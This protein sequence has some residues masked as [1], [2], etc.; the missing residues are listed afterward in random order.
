LQRDR[1]I[2][3]YYVS[4]R[5]GTENVLIYKSFSEYLYNLKDNLLPNWHL[6]WHFSNI[7]GH[8][9]IKPREL[10]ALLKK[11]ENEFLDHNRDLLNL[12][13]VKYV[14]SVKPVAG[15][16]LLRHKT[17]SVINYFL[18]QNPNVL[19]RAYIRD[20]LKTTQIQSGSRCKI[21]KY[22]PNVVQ[23]DTSLSKSGFLFLSDTYYPG[24]KVYVNGEEKRIIKADIFFRAVTLPAGRHEVKFIYDPLTFK[25]GSIISLAT[26]I[27]L[28]T[29]VG[30]HFKKRKK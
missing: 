6:P 25:I 12:M 11:H 24:W 10:G 2:F 19:P 26:L 1:G 17:L 21:V 29:C 13:N 23:I 8:A 15:M 14:V 18:F 4:P 30:Y 7:S 3:R 22:A 9:S 16:K 27:G 5:I 28:I 20:S